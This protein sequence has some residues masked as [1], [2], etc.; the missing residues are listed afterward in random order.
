MQ[1]SSSEFSTDLIFW[2][3]TWS[4]TF[5][6]RRC[7]ASVVNSSEDAEKSVRPPCPRRCGSEGP[8]P[9]P[10]RRLAAGLLP[11][12]SATRCVPDALRP[13]GCGGEREKEN[14]RL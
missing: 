11:E 5:K 8:T 2:K 4:R 12:P 10:R 13:R 9:S 3:N 7:D 1:A 14:P 6:V